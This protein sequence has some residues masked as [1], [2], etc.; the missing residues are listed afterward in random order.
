MMNNA[1]YHFDMTLSFGNVVENYVPTLF[2]DN[3]LW[4]DLLWVVLN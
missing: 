1:F 4:G 3:M 2:S